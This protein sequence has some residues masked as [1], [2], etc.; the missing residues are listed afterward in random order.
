MGTKSRMYCVYMK[1][2]ELTREEI[3]E[4]YNISDSMIDMCNHND[5]PCNGLLFK[6]KNKNMPLKYKYV[7]QLFKDGEMVDEGSEKYLCNKYHWAYNYLCNSFRTN[8]KATGYTVGSR[9]LTNEDLDNGNVD[10][11][12][13]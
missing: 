2:E 10:E 11:W 12:M 1:V 8:K 9:L 4:K 5:E 7:Y 6:Y 13:S 3:K